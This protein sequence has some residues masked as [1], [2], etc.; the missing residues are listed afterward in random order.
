MRLEKDTREMLRSKLA[1]VGQT[2]LT[3]EDATVEEYLRLA[4][5]DLDDAYDLIERI[6]KES[7]EVGKDPYLMRCGQ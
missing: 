6:R 1:A 3:D 2:S 7:A 4:L 5:A